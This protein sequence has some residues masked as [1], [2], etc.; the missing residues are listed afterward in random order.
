[1]LEEDHR[2]RL[3][4]ELDLQAVAKLGRVDRHR[5]LRVLL[6]GLENGARR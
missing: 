1:V 2:E 3:A 6:V 5:A 4:V